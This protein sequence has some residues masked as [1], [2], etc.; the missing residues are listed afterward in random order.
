MVISTCCFFLQKQH[1]AFCDEN[2]PKTPF[3]YFMNLF[4]Q[5]QPNLKL[6]R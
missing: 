4:I 2:C 5:G 3:D 6:T 1:Y